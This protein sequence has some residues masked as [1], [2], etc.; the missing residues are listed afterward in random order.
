MAKVNFWLLLSLA[1]TFHV[2]FA[3]HT[4]ALRIG[5]ASGR[6]SVSTSRYQPRKLDR[7]NL[8]GGQDVDEIDPSEDDEKTSANI[9]DPK[10]LDE[11][12]T[13]ASSDDLADVASNKAVY[14][15]AFGFRA[16][17]RVGAAAYNLAI[18]CA[19]ALFVTIARSRLLA[20]GDGTTN[21]M[22]ANVMTYGM[23]AAVLI[24]VPPF[25]ILSAKSL[26]EISESVR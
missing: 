10:I 15:A 13:A 4:G 3:L 1:A 11:G 18:S 8:R 20:T 24:Q 19:M 12:D 26:P 2:T 9:T 14:E 6:R 16:S 23:Y 22:I 17:T 5:L 25:L 7:F 21:P